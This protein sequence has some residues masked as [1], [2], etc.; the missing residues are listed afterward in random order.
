[1]IKIIM[2]MQAN[3]MGWPYYSFYCVL[4]VYH[5][6][7]SQMKLTNDKCDICCQFDFTLSDSYT[8]HKKK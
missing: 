1:M 3:Q 8:V 5:Q 4:F 7:L 6:G 2:M